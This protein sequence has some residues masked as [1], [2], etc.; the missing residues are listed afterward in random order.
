MYNGYYQMQAAY[1]QARAKNLSLV[2]SY[3]K[4]KSVLALFC[5]CRLYAPWH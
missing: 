1:A 5:L 4:K 2:K 3:F